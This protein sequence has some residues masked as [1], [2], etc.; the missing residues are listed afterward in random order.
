MNELQGHRKGCVEGAKR[1]LAWWVRL[2]VAI[3]TQRSMGLAVGEEKLR[4][5]DGNGR[6]QVLAL[7][8]QCG[9]AAARCRASSRS[10]LGIKA[11]GFGF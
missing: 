3:S 2:G 6:L 5:V 7:R 11:C 10:K 9:L 1:R 4:A 8:Q